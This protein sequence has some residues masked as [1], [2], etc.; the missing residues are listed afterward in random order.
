MEPFLN[1]LL[2]LF[3]IYRDHRGAL[4]QFTKR[5]LS[6]SF[7]S[8]SFGWFWLFLQPFVM[9]VAYTLVFGFIFKGHYGQSV[10]ESNWDYAIAVY[11]SLTVFGFATDIIGGGPMLLESQRSLLANTRVPAEVF[12]VAYLQA[13]AIRFLSALVPCLILARII[14]RVY[15][16]GIW[17]IPLVAGYVLFLLG[18]TFV[19]SVLGVIFPDVKQLIGLTT[20]ILMFSSAVFYPASMVPTWFQSINPVLQ[21]VALTR[22]F[23]LWGGTGRTHLSGF[24]V[25][26]SGAVITLFLGLWLLRSYRSRLTD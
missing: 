1:E 14:S 7:R 23:V 19:L 11:L 9:M 16:T 3:R 17:A 2:S 24:V 20:T 6:T 10:T 13:A 18:L 5:F 8:S 21:A 4:I 25:E 22:D 15:W 26:W 12:I